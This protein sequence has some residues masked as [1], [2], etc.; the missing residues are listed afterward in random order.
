MVVQERRRP[1]AVRPSQA[2]DG[3]DFP[4]DAEAHRNTSVRPLRERLHMGY[5]PPD[6]A[7]TVPPPDG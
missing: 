3:S 2:R 4:G 5:K 1:G 7:L 6:F